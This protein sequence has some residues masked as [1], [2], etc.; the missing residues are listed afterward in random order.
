MF[1][2]PQNYIIAFEVEVVVEVLSSTADLSGIVF[3][4]GGHFLDIVYRLRSSRATISNIYRF[5]LTL[6]DEIIAKEWF[7]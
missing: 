2:G 3:F 5:I 6:H 4:S 1:Q 7:L